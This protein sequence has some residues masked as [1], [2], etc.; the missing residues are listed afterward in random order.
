MM[1]SKDGVI[2][3]RGAAHLLMQLA[4]ASVESAVTIEH[5]IE[6]LLDDLQIDMALKPKDLR[7]FNLAKQIESECMT[8]RR[9]MDPFGE[10]V[11]ELTCHNSNIPPGVMGLS[12]SAWRNI[13]VQ[14]KR[15]RENVT[16]EQERAMD[17]VELYRDELAKGEEQ[18]QGRIER[19]QRVLSVM[20][21]VFSPLSFIA[22]VYGMNF[23]FPDGRPGISELRW[24]DEFPDNSLCVFLVML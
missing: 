11:G 16:G 24:D 20:I 1:R 10:A 2:H 6:K 4:R 19:S 23:Q 18:R 8:M 7:L 22:G 14:Q 15:L 17:L 21:S 5:Y 9:I 3:K 13:M 12:V